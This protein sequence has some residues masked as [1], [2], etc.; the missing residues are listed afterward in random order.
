M[1]DTL[2]L[3]I[4]D[5]FASQ[6]PTLL[7]TTVGSCI[8]VCLFDPS[9]RVGGMNHFMLP[10]G[11]GSGAA[12]G[13]YGGHAMGLLLAAM[14]RAGAARSRFVAAVFGGGHVIDAREHEGSVPARNI[15]FI[16]QYLEAARM[17]V[18]LFEVGGYAPRQV[19]FETWTGQTSIE[20]LPARPGR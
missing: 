20:L 2:T 6:R 14:E 16:H 3:H 13:S 1:P 15:A 4:G 12:T 7:R 8:A 10:D 11:P 9:T 19:S 5:V 17:R 18:R